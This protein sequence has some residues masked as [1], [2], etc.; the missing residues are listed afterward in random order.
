MIRNYLILSLVFLTQQIFSQLTED[1]RINQLGFYPNS[2]K[3]F[4]VVGTNATTFSVQNTSRTQTFYTGTL[5]SSGTWGLSGES[6]KIG[7]FTSFESLGE[8][9]IVVPEKGYSYNFAIDKDLLSEAAKAS[10]RYFYLNRASTAITS[11]NGGIY[12]RSLGHRDNTVLVHSSAANAQSRP[13]G[14][15]INSS[16][17]WYDAGD[18]GKYMMTA[19]I[20]TYTLLSTYEQYETYVKFLNLNIPESGNTLP[21][22]LDEA[23]YELDWMLTMQDPDDGGVYHKLTSTN[24]DGNVMPSQSN[25]TRYV[26]GK[27]TNV[28]LDFAST[29]AMASRIYKTLLPQ[30]AAIFL[31]AAEKAWDWADTNP[32]VAASQCPGFN[33]GSYDDSNISDEWE[34][35]AAEM[36]LATGD[37][38]YYNSRRSSILSSSNFRYLPTWQDKGPLALISLALNQDLLSGQAASDYT[39]ILNVL[40]STAN[41]LS[42]YQ[43]ITSPYRVAMGHYTWNFNWGSNGNAANQSY[44]LLTAYKLFE[45]EKYLNAG[46]ANVDYLLGRNATGYSFLTG[47]GDKTPMNPHH[48]ISLADNVTNPHPGMIIGGPHSNVTGDCNSNL[49]LS[50]LPAKRFTD[51][52]CSY[53]TN[54]ITVNWNAPIAFSLIALDAIYGKKC[55]QPALGDD[56]SV[57]GVS[58]P[59]ILRTNTNGGN[60]TWY[61]DGIQLSNTSATLTIQNNALS[62]GT[63]KV[64]RDSLGCASIDEINVTA[65]ILPVALPSTLYNDWRKEIAINGTNIS[66]AAT[67][68]WYTNN[69]LVGNTGTIAITGCDKNYKL[70][71]SISGCSNIEQDIQILCEQDSY[72]ETFIQIPGRLEVEDFDIPLVAGGSYR[73][74]DA[75]NNGAQNSSEVIYRNEGVDII[76][77]SDSDNGY[78]IGWTETNEW[79]EYSV[80]VTTTGTY[81]LVFRIASGSNNGSGTI[82][83][84][85]NEE[86]IVDN[87]SFNNTGGWQSFTNVT[88]ENVDLTIGNYILKLN[89]LDGGFNINYIDFINLVTITDSDGDGIADNSD[90]CPLDSNKSR[91]GVCG[92]NTAD[93]DLNNDTVIDCLAS[94]IDGDGVDDRLD[95]CPTNPLKTEVGVCGC[96]RIDS[97]VNNNGIIDCQET[98]EYV[99]SS[100]ATVENKNVVIIW[101]IDNVNDI[102]SF[103]LSRN[104]PDGTTTTVASFPQS[105][106]SEYS[107]TDNNL[108]DGEYTYEIK[109]FGSNGIE[110]DKTNSVIITTIPTSPISDIIY[111]QV[112]TSNDFSVTIFS[113]SA[114]SIPLY[115]YHAD[116]RLV[117][118]FNVATNIENNL[119]INLSSG[120]YFM[121]RKQQGKEETYK[122]IIID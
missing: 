73:D 24:F 112:G 3:V 29:M 117:G 99:G 50:N 120:L 14:T 28:T 84:L 121:H 20:S 77:S 44:I 35:A 70:Q 68:K 59:I 13:E 12:Q 52:Y 49:Y 107:F 71:T 74:L 23:M 64:I 33:T 100:S 4:A 101:D 9:V 83:L 31:T 41:D 6:V 69:T 36:Y 111:T 30:K 81:D 27:N 92:C 96:T 58:S 75:T 90:G 45:D 95:G 80:N 118:E 48:R 85:L 82:Q 122:F 108:S 47:F 54:E 57:C 113:E 19:G 110:I 116:G 78:V 76:R 66:P 17:G 11:Q 87:L 103:I 65:A 1:I 63:Y 39:Q 25:A 88:V 43:A 62:S 7:D 61:K 89:I 32:S 15:I 53:S 16:K 38:S 46:L 106:L 34:W 10:V 51:S 119:G 5:T 109:T 105:G 86:V 40:R 26:C 56:I 114:T 72:N 55:K 97:D 8:Y 102:S 79:L 37:I 93:L 115:F 2:S 98:I 104:N 42:N 94:D 67:Y 60:Y 21:D 18:Y 22:L 91:P